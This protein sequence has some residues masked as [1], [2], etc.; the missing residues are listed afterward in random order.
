MKHARG[1]TQKKKKFKSVMR[2][3]N[4]QGQL[5]ENLYFSNFR[6]IVDDWNCC[7]NK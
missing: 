4:I 5:V 3:M 7:N 6:S 2:G 1:I